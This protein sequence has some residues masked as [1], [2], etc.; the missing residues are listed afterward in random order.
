MTRIGTSDLD[1]RPLN[2]GGNVFGWTADEATSHAVLDA[3]VEG[4]GDFIDTADVYSAWSDGG[5]G[6]SETIIGTWLAKSGKRDQVVIAT[7]VCSKEDRKGLAADN[8][9]KAVDES[10]QRLQTDRIDLYWAHR[11]DQSVELAETLGAFDALVTAGKVRAIGAS[12]YTGARLTEALETSRREGF[13]SYAAVQNHYNLVERAEYEQDALPVAEANGLASLPYY[14]LAS[15][16]LTGKYRPGR[17]AESQRQAGAAK[18]LDDPRGP[19]VLEALDSVAAAH[20]VQVASVALAWLRQ[21][22]TVVAP[23]ASAR[24][25]EQLAPL[26]ASMDLELS[27]EELA[28]LDAASR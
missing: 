25:V 28:T 19:K 21:Q 1:V 5:A 4:G 18:Y 26:L 2:L 13:A 20:G 15:G 3:F 14:S 11:D 10:L 7:K 6:I 22:P 27:G 23:I 9:V 8:I 16:F 24:T 17:L 12:N